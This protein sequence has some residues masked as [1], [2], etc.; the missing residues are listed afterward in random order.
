MEQSKSIL[1]FILETATRRSFS[2]FSCALYLFFMSV[3]AEKVSSHK[4]D[5]LVN[6]SGSVR[7][8]A[9]W[10]PRSIRNMR[11]LSRSS[12]RRLSTSPRRS[13][14]DIEWMCFYVVEHFYRNVKNMCPGSSVLLAWDSLWIIQCVKFTCGATC[15][16]LALVLS[17]PPASL[18]SCPDTNQYSF[19]KIVPLLLVLEKCPHLVHSGARSKTALRFPSKLYLMKTSS[20]AEFNISVESS[21]CKAYYSFLTLSTSWYFMSCAMSVM[22]RAIVPL[23]S[24][25]DSSSRA[26]LS[27][28]AGLFNVSPIVWG[29]FACAIK[30]ATSYDALWASAGIVCLFSKGLSFG[31]AT[32]A[33][34]AN[35]CCNNL[36]DQPRKRKK[37]MEMFLLHGFILILTHIYLYIYTI[38][39]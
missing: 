14:S 12:C 8:S 11:T 9:S 7:W 31:L 21:N 38:M 32:L 26:D 19:P 35:L 30:Y 17:F 27:T 10:D 15:K 13:K 18:Q 16:S 39:G 6:Q 20:W 34:S 1:C 5:S 4:Y 33:R 3:R 36:K 24:G 2:T 25:T 22:R 29:F 28:A 23:D 37:V